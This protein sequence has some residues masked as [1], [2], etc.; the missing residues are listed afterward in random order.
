MT[1]K[2]AFITGGGSGIGQAAAAVLAR[3]RM[4]I[5]LAGR[6]AEELVEVAEVI[7]RSRRFRHHRDLRRE[8]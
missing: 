3:R 5:A 6:T 7:G 8:R 4:K 1:D 2:V